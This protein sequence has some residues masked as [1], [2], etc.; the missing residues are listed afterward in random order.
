MQSSSDTALRI[1]DLLRIYW[2]YTRSILQQI[3]ELDLQILFCQGILATNLYLLELVLIPI[4][5]SS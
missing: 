4:G 1:P 5:S 3:H 2:L